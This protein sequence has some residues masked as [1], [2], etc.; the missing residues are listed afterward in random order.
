MFTT[1]KKHL[2]RLA[3]S[4]STIVILASIQLIPI[5]YADPACGGIGTGC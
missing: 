5:V 3:V 1:L 4:L 2:A